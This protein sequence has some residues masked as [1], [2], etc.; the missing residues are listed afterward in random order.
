MAIPVLLLNDGNNISKIGFG[1]G[2]AWYKNDPKG[3]FNPT[4]VEVLK[5]AVSKGFIHIDC[6]DS[7]GT[8][9]EV[10]VAIKESG[11]IDESLKRLQL[12]YVDLYLLHNPFIIPTAQELQAAWKGLENVKTSRK[13]RSIGISNLQRN[14]VETIL[15]A[16]TITPAIN[17]LEYHPCLQRAHDYITWLRERGFVVSSF[18]GLAPITVGK[19]GPLDDVVAKAAA[20][21]G[22]VPSTILLRWSLDQNVV[23]ITTT[24]NIDRMDNYLG[25]LQLTLTREEME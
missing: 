1:T 18:K 13:A 20:S 22:V 16:A 14:H 24:T 17:Q 21:H 7:Y 23:P 8:E 5:Y 4:L 11:A 19:G 25:A 15:Q 12:E 3:P 10:G 9:P 2:I 6:A